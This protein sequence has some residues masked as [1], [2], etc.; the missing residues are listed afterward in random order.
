MDIWLMMK[1]L[2]QETRRIAHTRQVR[3]AEEFTCMILTSM[4]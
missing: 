2:S 1:V 4:F 3:E